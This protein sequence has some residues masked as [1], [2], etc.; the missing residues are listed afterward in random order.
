MNSLTK[1]CLLRLR[2]ALLF[3]ESRFD[4]HFLS[5]DVQP[6]RLVG[7]AQWRAYLQALANRPG[8]R[9]L[10][11]GS[12]LAPGVW[13][14]RAHFPNATY[15]GFDFLPGGNVDVVGD[16]HRLSSYFTPDEKFDLVFSAASFEHFA[17]PWVVA[18][19]IAKVLTVGGHVFVETHFSYAAHDRPWN[20]FQFSDL[21][22]RVLFPE[23]LGFECIDAGM[24]N[25][26]VGRFSSLADANLKNTPV[27]GLYCHAEY[28]GRKTRDVEGFDWGGLDVARLVAG[29]TY[30][31]PHAGDPLR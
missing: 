23:A 26:L 13:D 12:R 25:P 4:R 10:E 3:F 27:P 8:A 7:H 28:L 19:E 14:A 11:V 6:P 5:V 20:F 2:K 31:Q 18:T 21:G 9:I 29:T 1:R 22:L 24:S 15:V 17:M 30:P 16:A